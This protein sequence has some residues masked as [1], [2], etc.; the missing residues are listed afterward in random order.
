MIISTTVGVN[1]TNCYLIGKKNSKAVLIDPGDQPNKI[2]DM[3]NEN[4]VKVKKII[5]THG[6]FDHISANTDMKKYTEAV[7]CIH[8]NDQASLTDP[9]KNLSTLLGEDN[10][11]NLESP[12][13]LLKEGNLIEVAHYSFEILHTPGHSPGSIC[14]Y[15][16]KN[17]VL[18]S[19]DTIFSMGVGRTDF[20]NC[21]QEELISS[22][23]NKIINLPEDTVVYPG[24]GEKTTIGRFKVDVWEK[25][26]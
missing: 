9:N 24:H 3:I 4:N 5:N 12:E 2:K 18:I 15:D 6:H 14:L 11:V 17:S 13:C 10:S 8:Q 21:S 19:G 26:I 1:F 25:L 7:V 16:K 20:P 23:E 22:I